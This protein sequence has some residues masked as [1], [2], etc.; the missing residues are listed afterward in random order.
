[1]SEYYGS[2]GLYL[3]DGYGS[4]QLTEAGELDDLSIFSAAAFDADG[5]GDLDVASSGPNHLFLNDGSGVFTRGAFDDF[6]AAGAY[7]DLVVFDADLDGDVDLAGA[8]SSRYYPSALFL[9]DG[10]GVFTSAGSLGNSSQLTQELAPFD[11]DGDGDID[12]VELYLSW[13]SNVCRLLLNNGFGSF[14]LAATPLCRDHETIASIST[15][16]LDLDGDVDL[17]YDYYRYRARDFDLNLNDGTGH[18]TL[19]EGFERG[20]PFTSGGFAVLDVDG[21]GDGDVLKSDAVYLNDGTGY[22]HPGISGDC[23][24]FPGGKTSRPW[25]QASTA[26]PTCS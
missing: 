15:F 12:L 3:H 10:T 17:I 2:T 25:M 22:F 23:L 11:A 13:Q 5:D 8:S 6:A 7:Q 26:Y 19:V 16:D 9:N 24:G 18:F 21:D 1:M 4:F 20:L 14:S